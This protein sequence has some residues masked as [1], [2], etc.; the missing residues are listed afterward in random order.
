MTLSTVGRLI[1]WSMKTKKQI[2]TH[3]IEGDIHCASINKMGNILTTGHN[4]GVI[5]F[6]SIA[7]P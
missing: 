2:E 3:A 1:F 5:R 7:K 6:Y 4:N